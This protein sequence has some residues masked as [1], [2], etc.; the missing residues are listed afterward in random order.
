MA[1]VFKSFVG[2]P[3]SP[4]AFRTSSAARR[5]LT[6]TSVTVRLSNSL[7]EGGAA[8]SGRLDDADVDWSHWLIKYSFR[9]VAFSLSELSLPPV[10]GQVRSGMA[11]PRC[12]RRHRSSW[13]RR[14]WSNPLFAASLPLSSSEA[15]FPS[16]AQLTYFDLA[17]F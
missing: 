10:R 11:L 12:R 14:G 5:L 2:T 6:S 3:S 1:T 13:C 7:R 4:A 9:R 8:M 17:F 16:T 15:L